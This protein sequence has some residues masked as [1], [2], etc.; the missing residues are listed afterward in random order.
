MLAKFRFGA[1]NVRIRGLLPPKLAQHSGRSGLHCVARHPSHITRYDPELWKKLPRLN[2]MAAAEDAAALVERYLK[3]EG[4]EA[5][6][7]ESID[8]E[9]QLPLK[10]ARSVQISP[11]AFVFV[12][13]YPPELDAE[14]NCH[15]FSHFLLHGSHSAPV[16]EGK[17]NGAAQPATEGNRVARKYTPVFVDRE[18]REAHFVIRIYRPSAQFPDGG[19]LTRY[20]ESLKP[21]DP[22][23]LNPWTSRYA[24]VQDGVLGTTEGNLDFRTLNI[25]AGGTGI[26]PYVRFLIRNTSTRVNLLFCN[27]TLREILLKP[28]FDELQRRGPLAVRYLVTSEDPAVADAYT[29]SSDE[30][31]AFG[32]LSREFVE[33]F[34]ERENS[35]LLC[36]GPAGMNLKARQIAS[37]LGLRAAP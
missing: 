31:I 20:L 11:T 14:F 5:A 30:D 22:I 13:S 9:Q 3:G 28:L 36:C 32:K 35:L 15:V 26:T 4:F 10:L 21:Q 16:L 18:R 7:P 12:L 29:P 6:P 37:D 19:R 2:D 17:W 25:V 23:L 27:K 1:K 34:F 24:L 33:D 8:T